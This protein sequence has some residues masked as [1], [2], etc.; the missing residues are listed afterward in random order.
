ML[1]IAYS[2][3]FSCFGKWDLMCEYRQSRIGQRGPTLVGNTPGPVSWKAL[4]YILPMSWQDH[5]KIV[6]PL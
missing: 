2:T 6:I 5:A 3:L 4:A 1:F